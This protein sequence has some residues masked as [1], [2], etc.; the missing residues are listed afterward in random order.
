MPADW[1]DTL[2]DGFHGRVEYA[3]EFARPTGLRPGQRVEL[4]LAGVDAFG[5]AA[6]ND[7]P[8]L[9]V[10]AG[11]GESRVEIAALLEDRNRLVVEVELPAVDSHAAPVVRPPGREH[12]PG[13][14]YGEVR[15][16][17]EEP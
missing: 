3:R 9:E 13:G 4:V 14:L 1:G 17:I 10:P 16:E 8:L 7:S 5:S 6:L 2:G 11:G 15:L 12:S